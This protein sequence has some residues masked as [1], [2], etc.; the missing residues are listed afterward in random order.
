MEK[1]QVTFVF[2]ERLDNILIKGC[3]HKASMSKET[4]KA[5]TNALASVS[6]YL[7]A[8]KKFGF[9]CKEIDNEVIEALNE[10]ERLT[11]LECM[12]VPSN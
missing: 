1:T 7:I 8:S 9:S 11:N 3:N 6:A 2:I 4:R 10:F 5:A 12:A